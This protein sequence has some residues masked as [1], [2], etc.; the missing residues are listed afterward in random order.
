MRQ[1]GLSKSGEMSIEN[2][3]YKM[4]RSKNLIQKLFD[5]KFKLYGDSISL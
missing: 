4:L 5:K 3:A 1:S 2:I